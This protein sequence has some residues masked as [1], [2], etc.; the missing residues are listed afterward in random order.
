MAHPAHRCYNYYK[1]IGAGVEMYSAEKQAFFDFCESQHMAVTF[2][3]LR[4]VNDRMSEASA[5]EADLSSHFSRNI[6]L[7]VP[8]VSSPMDTIT[9]SSMAIAMA[10]LGGLG[11]IHAGLDVEEQAKEVERVKWHLN[12]LIRTPITAFP[13]RTVAEMESLCELRGFDFRSFPV[14]DPDSNRLLG[15][16]TQSDFDYC[17]DRSER[18][19]EGMT[20][21]A[22]VQTASVGID[23]E[24]AYKIMRENGKL[25]ALPLVH[26]DGRIGG[27]YIKSDVMRLVHGNPENYNLDADGRL[28]VGAAVPTDPQQAADRLW[29]MRGYVDVVVIDTARGNSR[30]ML[31][32]L[33]KLKET[34]EVLK[35][36]DEAVDIVAGNISNGGPAK[37]LYEA[38]ADGLRVGQGGGSICTTRR[39][40]GTGTPQVTAVYRCVNAVNGEIP[41]CSDGGI[42]DPGDIS[43]ALAAGA[44]SVMMGRMLAAT[45]ETP[46]E[47]IVENGELKKSLRGMGSPSAL[48][49]SA[50]SRQRYSTDGDTP[51]PE[52][53]ETMLSY[54]GSVADV[55]RQYIKYL[56]SSLEYVGAPDIDSHRWRTNFDFITNAGLR[57]SHPHDL[58]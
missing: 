26:E 11:I 9:E 23:H 39:N 12:G 15:M 34:I 3:D 37:T 38:G 51:A 16:F 56:R 6:E 50:A 13:H 18:I 58:T 54:R 10:K 4:L 41:V 40:T 35:E 20:P 24:E 46:G 21:L 47:V 17:E 28:L 8:I 43:I 42:K 36:T 29:A 45:K 32:T 33:N 55:V 49:E 1:S 7:K 48:A 53:V 31:P 5:A 44:N 14:V 19:E 25:S 27:L 30:H 52:G 2:D 22:E 57:E